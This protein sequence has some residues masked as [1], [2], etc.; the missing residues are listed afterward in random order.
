MK[1]NYSKNSF[2]LCICDDILWSLDLALVSSK[3]LGHS[4][5]F[6]RVIIQAE[7]PMVETEKSGPKIV[8]WAYITPIPK[9]NVI[10]ANGVTIQNAFFYFST[11]I[12]RI[13]DYLVLI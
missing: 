13:I 5:I 6:T 4:K 3:S 10:S 8:F 11:I 7:V 1:S 2:A 9:K 12:V